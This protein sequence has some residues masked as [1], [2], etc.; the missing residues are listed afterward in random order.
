MC[1]GCC[2]RVPHDNAANL[3]GSRLE[4]IASIRLAGMV[5]SMAVLRGRSSSQK[6]ALLLTFRQAKTANPAGLAR[7]DWIMHTQ[8]MCRHAQR[9]LPLSPSSTLIIVIVKTA[10]EPVAAQSLQCLLAY[11]FSSTS[12][13]VRLLLSEAV[14]PQST[15]INSPYCKC[16]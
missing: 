3:S 14:L 11:T 9:S 7:R 15:V 16:S 1:S 5:E 13:L 10:I 2:T 4:E 12:A 6:D 8:R